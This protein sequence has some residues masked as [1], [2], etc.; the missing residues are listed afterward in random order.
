MKEWAHDM[1]R[2]R[3]SYESRHIIIK[4]GPKEKAKPKSGFSKES[5][6]GN[7]DAHMQL[8]AWNH[9]INYYGLGLGAVPL[10]CRRALDVGCGA[11][12]L[13]SEL[14]MRCG[15]VIAIDLDAPTIGRARATYVCP[16]MVRIV[17]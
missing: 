5:A 1:F 15:E 16:N 4:M 12:R 9:N 10:N 2:Y 3:K 13:A 6:P 14:A 17:R 11:G 8:N 7:N